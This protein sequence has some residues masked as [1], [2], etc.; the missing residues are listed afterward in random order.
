MGGTEE[1]AGG[2]WGAD[3]AGLSPSSPCP[4]G[5]LAP[6]I[7]ASHDANRCSLGRARGS[8]Q[9]AGRLRSFPP[10]SSWSSRAW[11]GHRENMGIL[12]QV[13]PVCL[14]FPTLLALFLPGS[15]QGELLP[16]W[17]GKVSAQGCDRRKEMLGGTGHW[18]E[19][20]N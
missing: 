15:L 10:L 4:Q 12:C 2:L 20:L 3:K 11:E 5:L 13:T 7:L 8:R 14:S 18:E 1:A 16:G 17:P 19:R 9:L 6:K